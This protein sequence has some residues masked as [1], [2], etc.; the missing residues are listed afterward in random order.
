MMTESTKELE[1][2]GMVSLAPTI[3]RN[4]IASIKRPARRLAAQEFQQMPSSH[5]TICRSKDSRWE[6][7]RTA[8]SSVSKVT[9]EVIQLK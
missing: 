5:K 9:V 7:M 3:I 8:A 1:S 4:L 2:A 6:Q